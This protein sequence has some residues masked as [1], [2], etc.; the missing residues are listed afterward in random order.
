MDEREEIS[1]LQNIISNDSHFY[2]LANKKSGK[3]GYYLFDVD[4]NDPE[5]DSNYLINWN[6]KLDIGNCDMHMM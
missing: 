6:N 1:N 2:V 5:E 4:I 3:L